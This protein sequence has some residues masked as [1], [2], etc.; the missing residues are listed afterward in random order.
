MKNPIIHSTALAVVIV[1]IVFFAQFTHTLDGFE[2]GLWDLRVTYLSK[3]TKHDPSIKLILIDQSSLDWA[4]NNNNLSWPWPREMYSAIVDHCKKGGAKAILFD[5]LFSEPSFYGKQDDQR[6]ASSLIDNNSVGAVILSSTQG[7]SIQ[8]PKELLKP[9][10]QPIM[11]DTISHTHASFPTEPIGSAFNTLGSVVSIPDSDGITRKTTLVQSFDGFNVPS[12]SL[13]GYLISH[14]SSTYHYFEKQF[15]LNHQCT[16]LT[17]E[18]KAIINYH[19]PSQTYKTFNAASVIASKILED[20][21][22]KGMIPST[23]FKNSYVIIGVSAPGLMDLKSTPLQNVYPGAEIHATILDNLLHNDF[24]SEAPSSIT[25]IALFVII[26]AIL[27]GVRYH[28]SLLIGSLYPIIALTLVIIT[29]II[30]YYFTIWFHLAVF[31]VGITLA[32]LSAFGIKYFH[33][34]AQK[35]FIKNAFSRYISPQVIDSLIKHPEN[36]KLGGRR[37]TLSILFSDIEGFTT[38]ST[39]ME[40]EILARFLN[41]YLGLMS[42]IIMDLGGTIDKYEG[43]A[44]IAFWNAPL[45][46][47]DHAILAVEAA[48]QCQKR[49]H[50]YN[51]HFVERYGYAIKTRFGI[52]TGE[53][54]IGNLGTE[55]R[56]DYTF[57]GDAGNLASRLESANKQFS[58]YIMIS[59][60]TKLLLSDRY[61]C[62][63]LGLI[64]VVGRSLPVRVY[65]PWS[66]LS[67]SNFFLPYHEALTLL[68]TGDLN[69]AEEQ[70]QHLASLDFVSKSYL[71]IIQKIRSEKM[72]FKN[73]VLYLDEK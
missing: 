20:E 71:S 55:K 61:V 50:E 69:K 51:P 47:N 13:S 65:E 17:S 36:L 41:E 10:Y 44:I 29:S 54:I 66:S 48:L 38:I 2:N 59:E 9:I 31:I 52:H 23:T 40:P 68:Y 37:E 26:F 43:D 57:I 72:S 62:R 42:D 63:E 32:W 58:T 11:I 3:P 53:V 25:Y 16:P 49:L 39:H 35:R 30:T 28:A 7:E 8:W 24:V 12:L 5:M 67:D 6:F 1:L 14:P 33:E 70:F 22:K 21:G 18:Y 34:G 46:Q 15:C 64:G 56:F 45:P 19:G 27:F 60:D 73:G 4:E